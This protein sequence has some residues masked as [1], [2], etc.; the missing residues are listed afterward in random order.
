MTDPHGPGTSTERVVRGGSWFDAARQVR[1]A[2]RGTEKP[3]LQVNVIGFRCARA[4][5]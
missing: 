1:S 5:S 2:N 4:L 3:E